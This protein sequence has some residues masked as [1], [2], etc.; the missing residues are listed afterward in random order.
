MPFASRDQAADFE[1][2][3]TEALRIG[4]RLKFVVPLQTTET[5]EN[6]AQHVKEWQPVLMIDFYV[7]GKSVA[8]NN[9]GFDL[10]GNRSAKDQQKTWFPYVKGGGYSNWF[11]NFEYV[12]NWHEDGIELK[13]FSDPKTGRVRSHNYNGE[14]G[15][16]SGMTWSGIS[17][18][19]HLRMRYVP[20]GFMFDAKGPM[21]FS[22][23][24][25]SMENII[26]FLN[27]CVANHLIKMHGAS[28][29]ISNSAMY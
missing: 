22:N 13:N 29:W 14:Y 25:S 27:S 12:V 18:S 6:I 9:I 2:I 5:L 24:N 8:F 3:P 28:I 10:D 15:F 11:G 16:R 7:I 21:A 20:Q 1:N 17:S 23:N 4:R 19:R 26:G